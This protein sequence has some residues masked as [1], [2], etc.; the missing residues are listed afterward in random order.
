MSVDLAVVF[1]VAGTMLHMCRV[2]K[3][4]ATGSLLTDIVTTELVMEKRG[5]ALV[6]P[7]VDPIEIVESPPEEPFHTFFK[8]REDRIR[9][10][11]S[12]TPVSRDSVCSILRSSQTRMAELQETY[13]AVSKRYSNFYKACGMVV[14]SELREVSHVISTGGVPFLGLKAVLRELRGMGAEIYIASGDSMQ[15]LANLQGYTEIRMDHIY[16]VS[17]P[18]IKERIVIKLKESHEIVVMVGDGLNDL[19]A[20]RAADLGILTVQQDTHPRKELFLAADRVIHD[21]EELPC[22]LAEI[23]GSATT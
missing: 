6:V 8:E 2:A 1:D 23:V 11:C 15:S 21:I 4:L 16:P 9:I 5:R 14:D 17:T 19:Y 10:S 18:R 13:R 12:S 3:D 20:L 7:Q 22:I